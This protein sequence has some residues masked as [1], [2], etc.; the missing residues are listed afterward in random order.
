MI[1]RIRAELGVAEMAAALRWPRHDDVARY[2]QAFA[3]SMGQ[4]HAIAFGYGR[5]ALSIALQCLLGSGR[6]VIC[7]AYTCVVVAHAIVTSGNVPVFID[8]HADDFNMDLDAAAAAI[9]SR[10]GAIIATS[11][12]GHPVN[13]EHTDALRAAHPDVLMIQDCAH[14]FDARWQGRAV[15]GAGDFAIFGLNISKLM[16]SI[17]GGMLTTDDDAV[18]Q[19]LRAAR[20]RKC[21]PATLAKGLRRAAYLAAVVPAFMAWPYSVVGRLKDWGLLDHFVRYYRPDVI[22]MPADYLEAMSP[23]EARVGRAQLARHAAILT[24]RRRRADAWR[25]RLAHEAGLV[26]LPADEAGASWSHFSCVVDD[27][28]AWVTRWRARGIELGTLIEY[29]IPELPAYGAHP[30]DEMPHAARYARSTVNFPL[31]RDVVDV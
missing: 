14:S 20:D 15:Q 3:A 19:R 22:D 7:P 27:R 17:F 23:I 5:S 21:T 31:T 26:R 9:T 16:T 24:A 29:S 13:L 11:L 10:T 28:E 2:E 4:R 1:P 25:K 8:S 18:A 6:E 30:P 12:F